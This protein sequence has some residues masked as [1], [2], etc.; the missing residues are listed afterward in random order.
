MA[1]TI[2]DVAREAGVSVSTVSR[3]LNNGYVSEKTRK[4]VMDALEGFHA[5]AAAQSLVTKISKK[6]AVVSAL[7]SKYFFFESDYSR[8]LAGIYD[9]AT[10]NGYHLLLDIGVRHSECIDLYRKRQIDGI[11]LVDS[12]YE[13]QS[14]LNEI[15]EA[16]VPFVLLGT[17]ELNSFSSVDV[18][19]HD[20][21]YKTV[22][23]LIS[24]GH[25]NIAMINSPMTRILSVIKFNGYLDALKAAGIPFDENNLVICEDADATRQWH[26]A[27]VELLSRP[28]RPTAIYVYSEMASMELYSVA[29]SMNLRIPED[30]SVA[31]YGNSDV[32]R[33]CFPPLTTAHQPNYEKGYSVTELLC[34]EI[35]QINNDTQP[36]HVKELLSCDLIIRESCAP[37]RHDS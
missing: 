14:L 5:N 36:V 20:I 11:I 8:I 34:K 12:G 33:V 26:E 27:S 17:S 29:R 25:R 35:T 10:A 31:A 21:A 18:D 4:K 16:H 1:K 7:P 30:L 19:R 28:N 23:Y 6:I 22:Q 32:A 24:L 2:Y 13:G 15:I 3:T 9:S 37:P